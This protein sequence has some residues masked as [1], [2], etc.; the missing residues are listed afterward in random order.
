MIHQFGAR[1]IHVAATHGVLV[2]PAIERL[3]DAPIQTLIITDTI[4]L[5]PAKLLPKI[6]VLSVA[7]LL[8]QAIKRIHHDQ[9]ISEMFRS[10]V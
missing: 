7:T 10:R 1:E 8:G 9:S 4:P 3:E 2:G 6:K 5:A